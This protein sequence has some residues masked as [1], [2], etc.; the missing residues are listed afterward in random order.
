VDAR[1]K[2]Q[3]ALK[4][5]RPDR[6]ASRELRQ[7]FVTEAEIT[8]TLEHPGVVPI[9]AFEEDENGQP[10]Y[11][12][13]FIQGRTLAE[14]IQAYHRSAPGAGARGS[15]LAFRELLQRFVSVCQTVAYAHSKGVIH[16]DLKPANIMLG[17]YGETLVLD[18]GVAKRV[19]GENQRVAGAERRDAPHSARGGGNE[20]TPEP[21]TQAGQVL[22]T[23]AYMS[24]EQARGEELGP[25]ADIYALGAILYELLCGRPAYQGGSG[26]EVLA[27]VRSGPPPDPSA[28]RK[29]VP[30]PLGAICRKA[31]ARGVA[32]RYAAAAD[33][34]R[35]VD[36]WLADEP[37]NAY[38]EPW[39]RKAG[40]WVKRHRP[41][42][43]GA[44]ALLLAAIP[45]SILIAVNREQARQQAE[46]DKL[47]IAKQKNIAEAN[48]NKALTARSQA[49]Q[50]AAQARKEASKAFAIKNFFVQEMLEEATPERNP[51]GSQITVREVLDRTARKIDVAFQAQP[52][53]AAAVRSTIGNAYRSLG[54]DAKAEPHL[55]LALDLY[56]KEMGPEA[57]E[58]LTAMSSLA[59][60]L[61]EQG[62]LK[63]A[64]PLLRTSLKIRQR[65][66]GDEHPDSLTAMNNLALLLKY[67]HRLAEAERLYR[68]MLDLRRRVQFPS[69]PDLL[70]A[71]NNLAL[72]VQAQGKLEEAEGLMRDALA[73]RR[74]VLGPEHPNTLSSMH[75]LALIVQ[76][77]GALADAE[78]LC[79]Q[80]LELRRRV[81][82]PQHPHTVEETSTLAVLLQA[83]NKLKEAET[84]YRQSLGAYRTLRGPE[85][86][87]TVAMMN[88]LA[89][90]LLDLGKLDEAE[91]LFRDT[92]R[93]GRKVYSTGD[94]FLAY[95]LFG[96]GR[97]LTENNKASEAEQPLREALQICRKTLPKG[98]WVT[99]QTE[100]LLG[101]CVAA[102]RRYQEAEPFLLGGYEIMKT[103][104]GTPPHRLGQALN[105]IVKMYEAWGKPAKAAEWRKKLKVVQ[106][107]ENKSMP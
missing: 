65:T 7:R 44:A 79:R 59:L 12:M 36:R 42:V 78:D 87:T 95:S 30:K 106:A 50:A 88:N 46:A 3:V 57:P 32:D 13:R 20:V 9:Y 82:G 31:M 93:L 48:E 91:P 98:Y 27:Q 23:P 70:T 52:E 105:R 14:A 64:I 72:L 37:V 6:L 34:G 2:R 18:W 39:S 92:Q 1:L 56:R 25:A 76:A 17:D 67:D 73:G 16:R 28:V 53:V 80:V 68:R 104:K 89:M 83:R 58:T 15:P 61:G 21:L 103:A 94:P 11:A 81:Q 5:I 74:Q 96:L 66:Q 86:P 26:T 43:T 49:E 47:E 107:G 35:D 100:N 63:E 75:N 19:G 40:R 54:L 97:C 22:G 77:K 90:V 8:S 60:A 55:R 10:Y 102:Q 69:H 62:K 45:L 24:P 4:E 71:L 85:H 99:G 29:Q 41:L 101:S 51:V 38:R 33:L 84:L